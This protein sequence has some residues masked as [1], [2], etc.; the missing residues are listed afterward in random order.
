[1]INNLTKILYVT[2]I[3]LILDSLFIYSNKHIFKTQVEIVQ[4]SPMKLN[5]TSTLLCYIVMVFGLYYFIIR[6]N[7]SVLDAIL[8]GI[9]IYSVFE[10]T[11]KSLFSEWN[12]KTVALDSI[13]G[14]LL[15]GTTTYILQNI[16]NSQNM[17][18]IHPAS[19]R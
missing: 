10:L 2:I 15:F 6:D 7:K 14:G 3:M 12:Y 19:I 17:L 18:E 11:N 8:L 13:W 4:K 5:F 16:Y 1:M 9:T